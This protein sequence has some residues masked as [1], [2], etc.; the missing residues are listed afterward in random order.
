MIKCLKDHYHRNLF[1]V[2][3]KRFDQTE[4]LP[5]ISVLPALQLPGASWN[6]IIKATAF[7]CFQRANFFREKKINI[8]EDSN[9]L[10]EAFQDNLKES[11]RSNYNLVS[12]ELIDVKL[13]T[14]IENEI[15]AVG[16]LGNK[17]DDNINIFDGSVG[18]I[19][20]PAVFEQ[21]QE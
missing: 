7:N 11:S 12:L 5:K 19:S 13:P 17:E 14:L 10:F 15:P 8:F 9:N 6:D 4:D 18:N 20:K 1:R 16:Y 2:I 3:I 21:K